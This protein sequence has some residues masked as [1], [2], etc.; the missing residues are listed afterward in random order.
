MGAGG[1]SC[2][3]GFVVCCIRGILSVVNWYKSV[4]VLFY[5]KFNRYGGKAV[6][7]SG[8][9]KHVMYRPTFC[10]P[11]VEFFLIIPIVYPCSTAPPPPLEKN[12]LRFQHTLNLN[13]FKIKILHQPNSA[14]LNGTRSD[15]LRVYWR[16]CIYWTNPGRSLAASTI[17]FIFLYDYLNL[18]KKIRRHF[19]C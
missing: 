8:S 6:I 15:S 12:D 7:V 4:R 3:S 16:E 14:S 17:E 2:F 11:L 18:H 13:I 19:E 9:N 1:Y 5:L 10:A